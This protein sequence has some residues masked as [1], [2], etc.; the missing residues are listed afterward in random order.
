MPNKK[1]LIVDDSETVLLLKQM[2]HSTNHNEKALAT[3]RQEGLSEAFD[4]N[5]DL[6]LIDVIKPKMNGCKAMRHIR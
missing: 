4:L 6:I 2:I 3:G 5:L 1:I